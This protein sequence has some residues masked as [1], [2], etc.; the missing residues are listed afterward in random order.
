M[1]NRI[2]TLVKPS[3][4]IRVRPGCIE[5]V[6]RIGSSLRDL[7]GSGLVVLTN[8]LEKGITLAGLG[9]RNAVLVGKRLEL[10]VGPAIC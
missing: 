4:D 10:G 6:T 3:L 9:N 8:C 1:R 7:V 5:P 2:A